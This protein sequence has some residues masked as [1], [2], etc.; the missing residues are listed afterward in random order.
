MGKQYYVY[1]L[2]S[3]S[4]ILYVGFTSD[5]RKR[6]YEHKNAVVEGF[7]KKYK[8]NRLVYYEVG[9]S[10]DGVLAREKQFKNWRREKKVNL[11]E[12]MNPAWKDLTEQ[13]GV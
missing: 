7:S 3:L 9:D 1:I 12:K 5:L 13:L 4:G 10:F 8:C 6:I 11:I 2:S